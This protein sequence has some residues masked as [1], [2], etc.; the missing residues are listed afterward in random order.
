ML[1]V[2]GDARSLLAEPDQ[3]RIGARARREALGRDVQAFEQVG[4]A[5]A[6]R[7]DHEHDSRPELQLELGVGAVVP[8]RERPDD[9]PASRIGMIKYEKSSAAPWR[10]AGRSG[11]ISFSRSSS[12]STDSIPSRRNSGLK[13]I[14]SAS[15]V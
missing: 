2:H 6:V 4:L 3:L 7:P 5:G 10:T 15:P 12:P 14:S 8:E 9:Q 1:A 11:L 13:P